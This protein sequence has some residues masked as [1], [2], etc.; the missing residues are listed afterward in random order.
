LEEYVKKNTNIPWSGFIRA[1]PDKWLASKTLKGAKK[2]FKQKERKGM[3]KIYAK[4][5]SFDEFHKYFLNEL[6]PHF[7]YRYKKDKAATHRWEKDKKEGEGEQKH[8]GNILPEI[9]SMIYEMYNNFGDCPKGE[10]RRPKD[11]QCAPKCPKDTQYSF[12][13]NKCRSTVCDDKTRL[14]SYLKGKCSIELYRKSDDRVLFGL[15]RFL[16]QS[17]RD[18]NIWAVAN[19]LKLTYQ[20]LNSDE[21]EYLRNIVNLSDD[22]FSY[23]GLIRSD[24]K[25]SVP[26][27]KK[28]YN[29][30]VKAFIFNFDYEH[31]RKLFIDAHEKIFKV[32]MDKF[33]TDEN[34]EY[35]EVVVISYTRAK[36]LVEIKN[37]RVKLVN[38]L[39]ISPKLIKK[40]KKD[41]DKIYTDDYAK[42]QKGKMQ[43][44][45]VKPS[46]DVPY[47]IAKSSPKVHLPDLSSRLP[48]YIVVKD[49]ATPAEL[50]RMR[51]QIE[52]YQ[53][54]G[55]ANYYHKKYHRSMDDEEKDKWD[56]VWEPDSEGTPF[57]YVDNM[58]NYQRRLL[59]VGYWKHPSTKK[60]REEYKKAYHGI[61]QL[62]IMLLDWFDIDDDDLRN[63][64]INY[65]KLYEREYKTYCEKG[66]SINPNT[67]FCR[68]N[69][70]KNEFRYEKTGKCKKIKKRPKSVPIITKKEKKKHNKILKHKV[71][72]VAISQ[73]PKKELL[74]ATKYYHVVKEDEK[75]KHNIPSYDFPSEDDEEDEEDEEDEPPTPK[76]GKQPLK[77]EIKTVKKSKKG[78]QPLKYEIKTVK[79]SKKGKEPEIIRRAKGY[80]VVKTTKGIKYVRDDSDEGFLSSYQDSD[81]EQDFRLPKKYEIKTVKK[82]KISL[83]KP[84]IPKDVLVQVIKETEEKLNK[85]NLSKADKRD[86]NIELDLL[87]WA[88]MQQGIKPVYEP[89][90]TEKEKEI[91]PFDEWSLPPDIDVHQKIDA[92]MKKAKEEKKKEKKDFAKRPQFITLPNML[93]RTKG[94]PERCTKQANFGDVDSLRRLTWPCYMGKK[95]NTQNFWN[96][97][98]MIRFL[99]VKRNK[100]KGHNKFKFGLPPGQKKYTDAEKVNKSKYD[101]LTR[102][103]KNLREA[104]KVITIE[105]KP[106]KKKK[107][108][109]G[110]FKTK[111]ATGQLPPNFK[112]NMALIEELNKAKKDAKEKGKKKDWIES[113]RPWERD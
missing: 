56:P 10:V 96:Y 99:L 79:K 42:L 88:G 66:K 14:F 93:A 24:K 47:N 105:I 70:K 7:R 81:T 32:Y 69:C 41:W 44:D 23:Y 17:W 9:R 112:Y 1:E 63:D 78:K 109:F 103:I 111:T 65:M 87:D 28:N 58:T 83:L 40:L 8:W 39:Y 51:L 71:L 35:L 86:I 91:M 73:L 102:Y 52:L 45:I 84:D 75:K 30:I 22:D 2:A 67:G 13:S 21:T 5:M 89:K 18:I 108:G 19:K 33:L 11:L 80:D 101:K 90:K 54:G 15:L 61:K 110:S 68:K 72:E 16:L 25:M 95:P 94:A 48:S 82:K 100:I 20:L 85:P 38:P 46:V 12:K 4:R 50:E 107:P 6:Y 37:K 97:N 3:G 76:K 53:M 31:V 62:E 26:E 36:Q 113:Y 60:L 49:N 59:M 64:V 57:Y 77:Y 43:L 104:R 92:S 29:I 98:N 106:K 34:K 55:L 27:I 74:K